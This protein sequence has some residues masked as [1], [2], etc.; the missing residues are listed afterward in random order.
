MVM[1]PDAILLGII[2]GITEWLPV[3]SSGHL[4]LVQ[5][6]MGIH[7]P[8]LFDVLLHMATLIVILTVFRS[9]IMN[10]AR[11]VIRKD[12]RS[13]DGRL[14]L[15]ILAGSAPT[16]L[17]G[18]AF[19]GFFESQFANTAAVGAGLLVTGIILIMT[20]FS[21]QGKSIG[22]GKSL[23]VGAAQGIAIMPGISRSG[24]TIGTGLLLGI[25]R[26]KI[27]RFSFLLSVPAVLGATLFLLNDITCIEPV[28]MIAGMLAS[29]AVGYLSLKMVIRLV[30]QKRFYLFAAYCWLA[31]GFVIIASLLQ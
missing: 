15:F 6:Y 31:G 18:F 29:V 1:L 14:F 23:V 22:W 13:E 8:V 25:D 28:P 7:I 5:H 11:A 30:L 10:I 24:A 19:Q 17:I 3:S 20:R 2:Q 4:A 16:G 26:E 12:F 9:D 21:S 27:I